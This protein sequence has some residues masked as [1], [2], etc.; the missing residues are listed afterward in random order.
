MK[1]T[2][3][4]LLILVLSLSL[5]VIGCGEEETA[6]Q[7]I[8]RED[9]DQQELEQEVTIELWEMYD[10]ESIDPT[11]DEFIEQFEEEH[12]NITVE[13]THMDTED[14]R[15]NTQT[16]YMGGEA[17][18]LTISPFDH[19][20]VFSQMG[21]ATDIEPLM[22]E[23]MKGKFTEPAL[24]GME[25]GGTMYGIPQ[26]MGNH[27]ALMYNKDLVDEP[28]SWSDLIEQAKE[29]TKDLDGDGQIDQ[30]GFVTDI[31]EAFFWAP[32][33]TGFEGWFFDED[34][35]VDLDNQA[36]GDALNFVH[37][38][39]YEHEVVPQE[40]DYDLAHSLFTDGQA[41]FIINGDW[42]F[43]QYLGLEDVDVGL[44]TIP[45]F[46]ETGEPGR[47]VT[48]G[49]G[50]ILVDGQPIEE[51]IASM[52]FIDFMTSSEVQEEFV[53]RHK[54]LPSNAAVF[55]MD[56][57]QEDEVLQT[58]AEQMRQGRPMPITPQMRGVWDAINPELQRVIT[59]DRDPYE[60]PARM[61]EAA[62]SNIEGMEDIELEE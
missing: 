37:E 44:A 13:R 52:K 28:E 2:F 61:Q 58:S 15:E 6:E 14:L 45:T 32:F 25:M 41:G 17:P 19:A 11:L 62:E 22:S 24:E 57:I 31:G 5:V 9:L 3:S 49:Q 12:P 27:L 34:L 46:D 56:V 21:I 42:T 30:Y 8:P 40:V 54:L 53:A 1:K 20:G 51:E 38:L 10:S 7:D 60:A 4:L 43:D 55:D 59:D 16:A 23:E 33:Y 39:I 26:S 47:P 48:S 50:Y 36:A 35:N 29:V 18:N